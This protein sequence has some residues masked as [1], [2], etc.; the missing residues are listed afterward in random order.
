VVELDGGQHATQL[1]ADQE[2]TATLELSGYR[3]L[4]F[5]N[6]EVIEPTEAVMLQITQA[7]RD[8]HP[9][10]LPRRAREGKKK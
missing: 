3:V 8:P 9:G 10:P 4:R 7:L 1:E 2:R 6:H 5:W